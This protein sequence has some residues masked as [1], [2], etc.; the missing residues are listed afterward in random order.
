M[1]KFNIL[2]QKI[3][4]IKICKPEL[5][6]I[7]QILDTKNELNANINSI[8]IIQRPIP[9]F[10]WLLINNFHSIRRGANKIKNHHKKVGFINN[11]VRKFYQNFRF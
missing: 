4:H 6:N 8:N 5:S 7:K 9:E 3:I 1:L 10:A 11:Q 2:N